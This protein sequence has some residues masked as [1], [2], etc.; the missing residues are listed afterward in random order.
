[1]SSESTYVIFLDSDDELVDDCIQTC[2]YRWN[3]LLK[4]NKYD[5]VDNI[6]FFMKGSDG[7]LV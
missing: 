7:S 2:L 4:E 5:H 3:M 1:M 6:H